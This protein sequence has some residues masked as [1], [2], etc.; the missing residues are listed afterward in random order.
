M[1][2]ITGIGKFILLKLL[3][4]WQYKRY[5]RKPVQQGK[6]IFLEV[7]NSVIGNSLRE[8]YRKIS[9]NG[10]Y[11]VSCHFLQEGVGSRKENV[12][13]TLAFL[14]DM[15]TAE[16][17]FLSEANNCFACFE[18]RSE[19]K[20]I[21]LWHGCGAFKR[22]GLSS[23]E[24]K[25]GSSRRQQQKYPLYHNLDLVT[26]SSPEVV[27][28]YEEAM[29]VP[30]QVVQPVGISRT[31]VFFD[32]DY[33][34]DAKRRVRSFLSD[35]MDYQDKKIIFYAPTFRGDVT[36]AKAPDQLDL[37][38]MKRKLGDKYVLLIKHHPFVKHL[39][40]IPASCGDFAID[41]TDALNIDDLICAGDICISDYSSLVFEYA[42][43]E[44]PIFFFAYDLDSYNDWRGFFYDYGSLTP[45]PVVKTTAELVR[46]IQETEAGFDSAQVRAFRDKFM[47]SCDGSVTE[48][49]LQTVGL[50]LA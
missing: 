14:A 30:E 29:G 33:I 34:S 12:K 43:F 45:G 44:K 17:V 6:V 22:F 38:Y 24:L 25:F 8:V 32:A 7:R 1:S 21:Q 19:T 10:S 50:R 49:I 28:A 16:Y 47:A 18:K 36:A 46:C 9:E 20:V 37:A 4:P 31:D 23:A 27:W 11:Q 5:S 40:K 13:R 42:L 3:Y 41:V 39:P 35:H 2:I 15:A 26:V 48:R